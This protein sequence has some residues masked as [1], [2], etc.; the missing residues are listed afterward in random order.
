M[1]KPIILCVDDEVAILTSL[2]RQLKQAFE[3]VY[4]YE[5]AENADEAL[6]ILDEIEDDRAN[7][8]VVVSDWLMPGMKGDEFLIQVHKRFPKVVKIMLTGQAEESAMK[9]ALQEAELHQL[10][11]KPWDDRE[12]IESIKSGLKKIEKLQE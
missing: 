1:A 11:A 4:A 8:L 2:K 10:F 9:R 5:T 12:L 6:E 3:D 7:V